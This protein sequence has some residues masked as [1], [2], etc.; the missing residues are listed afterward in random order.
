MRDLKK[1][2]AML[3][4]AVLFVLPLTGC[5]E[6]EE[7]AFELSVCVG[8]EPVSL[9]PIYAEEICDQSVLAHLYENLMKASVD[10]ATGESIVTNGIA[11]SVDVEENYDGTVTYTFRL[12]DAEWSDGREVKA[13]DFVY[14][15]RRLANPDSYSPYAALLSVVAGYDEARAGGD[16]SLLQISAK[17]TTTL[18]VVLDGNY[19][20]FLTEVCTSPAT[21][22]LRQDVVQTLKEAA[23]EKNQKAVGSAGTERWW[24]DAAALVTNGPYRVEAWDKGNAISLVR[25]EKYDGN[26][27]APETMTFRFAKTAQAAHALYEKGEVDAIWPLTESRLAELAASE[28]WE[29]IPELGTYTALFNCDREPFSDPLIRQAMH[30]VIDRNALAQIAG[31]TALPAE[32]I[33]PHGV[34]ENEEGDFRTLGKVHLENDP[35]LYE[36]QCQQA[37]ALLGEA[38]YDSGISLGEHAFLYLNE[39]NNSMV[40]EALCQMWQ[41]KLGMRI[42]PVG[43]PERDLWTALRTGEYAVAAVEL[44]AVGNDAECFLMEWTSDSI[45]NV[46]GYENTAYD[47]LMAIIASAPDG[48]A[49]MGCLHDAEELLMD[50]CVLAPLYTKGTGWEL[51]ETLAGGVRDARGWFDFSGVYEKSI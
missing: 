2:T 27:T 35:E 8:E 51:Q 48:T 32:G 13:N 11:K 19:D 43:M 36:E 9:D 49:R 5:A 39:G 34:P 44:T 45:D 17:N 4:I 18:E 40:A 26:D 10:R 38:G 24:S 25:N 31:V 46:V 6:E 23:D 15:W 12:R 3:L 30:M 16:M 14:A 47:T 50:S 7:E 22:P 29:A 1:L 20:W 21:M 28:V 42:V 33:I 37:F 41:E